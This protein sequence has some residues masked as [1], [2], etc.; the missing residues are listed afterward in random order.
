MNRTS[1]ADADTLPEIDL[2]AAL[3][4]FDGEEAFLGKLAVLLREDAGRHL[5]D[6][7]EGIEQSDGARVQMAARSL[8]GAIGAFRAGAALDAA[9]SLERIAESRNLQ[10]APAACARLEQEMARL[11][12]ALARLPGGGIRT[13]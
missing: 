3:A 2:T 1:P 13:G 6:I 8:K 4:H 12:H 11:L 10:H 5:R 9:R 7:H